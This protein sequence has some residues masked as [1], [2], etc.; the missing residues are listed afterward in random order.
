MQKNI[1]II[2]GGWAGLSAAVELAKSGH[3]ITLLEAGKQLG[4]RARM[5]K[6]GKLTVDN[7]QHLMIGAYH[8]MLEIMRRVGMDPHKAFMRRNLFLDVQNLDKSSMR[9]K[10]AN[11]PAPLHLL[12][13]FLLC[14]GLGVGERISSVLA[15]N[16]LMTQNISKDGDYSVSE[17]LARCKI[18]PKVQQNMLKPLCIAALNTHPDEASARIFVR[19]LHDTFKAQKQA[20]D[21]LFPKFNLSELFADPVANYLQRNQVRVL[22]EHKVSSLITHKNQV[23]G[24]ILTD[25][26]RLAADEIIVATHYPQAL[27]ILKTSAEFA[28]ISANLEQLAGEPI[29]TLYFQFAP[30]FKMPNP[31]LGVADGLSQWIVDRSTVGDAGL[32][33]VVISISE[34]LHQQY[35]RSQLAIEVLNEL[36]QLF[37]TLGQPKDVL[38]LKDAPATFKSVVGI[39]K[40]R[41]AVKTRVQGLY[42]AG[43]YTATEL[44]AT[45]EGAVRSGRECARHIMT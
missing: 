26:Q 25:N 28:D 3:K 7:G 6:T 16:N 22:L 21:F 5:V 43:D 1:I 12:L 36:K 38:V 9:L 29:T 39:D 40:I 44:P 32:L 15:L 41:P 45:L 35:S 17:L 24:V 8:E 20:S 42:L 2:G 34:K 23:K 33:A 11:L 18:N 14:K 19:T 31:M 27:K 37:P 30:D 10:T 13:G 4:G